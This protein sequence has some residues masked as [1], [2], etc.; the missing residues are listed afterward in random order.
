MGG[1]RIFVEI[2]RW[3]GSYRWLKII[4]VR[5]QYDS[6]LFSRS[7]TA[8]RLTY[9]NLSSKPQSIT[10]N[11]L[12]AGGFDVYPYSCKGDS[13]GP[14]SCL[15]YTSS[16]IQKVDQVYL[17]SIASVGANCK[18]NLPGIYTDVSKYFRWIKK[19][20]RTAWRRHY[21]KNGKNNKSL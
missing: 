14:L 6:I 9:A 16:L 7:R 3:D 4:S 10:D 15:K 11:M 2:L 18:R 20:M 8:C 21:C 19:R 17:C 12:C 1:D 13:G 5:V